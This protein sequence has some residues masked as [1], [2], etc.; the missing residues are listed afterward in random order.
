MVINIK[1]L[2]MLSFTKGEL[3]GKIVNRIS[4]KLNK[5][6]LRRYLKALKQIIE[7]N[8][9]EVFTTTKPDKNMENILKIVFKDKSV[10]FKIDKDLIAGIKIKDYDT[11]YEYNL[12]NTLNSMLSYIK[13]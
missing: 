1:Q 11:I 12:K 2:A 5:T 7:K 8:T 6:D 3:N 13:E 10:H 4:K 9:V